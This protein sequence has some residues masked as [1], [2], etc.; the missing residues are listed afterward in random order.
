MG[1]PQTQ[2]SLK[3][4]TEERRSSEVMLNLERSLPVCHGCTQN[5]ELTS[6][7][8]SSLEGQSQNLEAS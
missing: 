3:P 1:V 6:G 2:D 8:V 7:Q 4:F 5:W